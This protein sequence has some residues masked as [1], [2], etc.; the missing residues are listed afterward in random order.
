M[1]PFEE[2]NKESLE[3]RIFD[4]KKR[5]LEKGGDIEAKEP[6]MKSKF[7]AAVDE[8][9]R[10][11]MDL[12]GSKAEAGVIESSIE[13]TFY[14][15]QISNEVKKLAD[16]KTD[17][18]IDTLKK[19]LP[20]LSNI[21]TAISNRADASG[22]EMTYSI[23]DSINKFLNKIGKIIGSSKKEQDKEIIESKNAP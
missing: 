1:L 20:I 10:E 16:L 3:N 14:Q 6:L 9:V 11:L 2:Q 12:G 8:L 15:K 22:K 19:A 17:G 5:I 21:L 18:V 13:G 7:K 4:L 23:K